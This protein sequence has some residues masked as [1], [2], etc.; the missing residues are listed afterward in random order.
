MINPF[1]IRQHSIGRRLLR[2][3]VFEWLIIL[4]TALSVKN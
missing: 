4:L 3:L 1:K 2:R